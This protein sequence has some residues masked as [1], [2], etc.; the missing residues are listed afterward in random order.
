MKKLLLLLLIAITC[1]SLSSCGEEDINE[2]LYETSPNL[3][4]D[5]ILFFEKVESYIRSFIK[6]PTRSDLKLKTTYYSTAVEI[7]YI[8]SNPEVLTD[9]GKYVEHKYDEDVVLTCVLKLEDKMYVFDI[10]ITSTGIPDSEKLEVTK[11]WLQDY[12][13]NTT[14][15]RKEDFKG[16]DFRCVSQ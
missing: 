1:I 13:N 16:F 14:D 2:P 15:E 6:S 8:S 9:E 10:N 7:M 4:E 11:K 3:T 5:D 12:L